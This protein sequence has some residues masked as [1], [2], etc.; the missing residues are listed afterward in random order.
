MKQLENE[1]HDD[2]PGEES[3]CC[4]PFTD[5]LL[6]GKEPVINS[7][8]LSLRSL[9]MGVPDHFAMSSSSS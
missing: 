7:G 9:S 8:K 1:R 3:L 2:N 5:H 4:D 6:D